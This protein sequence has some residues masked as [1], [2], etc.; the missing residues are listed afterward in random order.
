MQIL[1]RTPHNAI[2]QADETDTGIPVVVTFDMDFV[3]GEWLILDWETSNGD[4]L[5]QREIIRLSLLALAFIHNVTKA[6]HS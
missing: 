3:R 2:V 5:P 1:A 6:F 4:P